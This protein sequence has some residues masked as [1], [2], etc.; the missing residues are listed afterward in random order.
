MSTNGQVVDVDQ[1]EGVKLLYSPIAVNCVDVPA[2]MGALG[3]VTVMS[4]SSVT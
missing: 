3:W 2:L 4:V 1:A